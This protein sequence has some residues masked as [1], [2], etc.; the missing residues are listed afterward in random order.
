MSG[1]ADHL[2]QSTWFA[3]AAWLLAVLVRKDS[4]RIRYWIWLCAS[5]KFLV[6]FALLAWAGNHIVLE[7]EARS[8]VLPIVQQVA[9]PFAGPAISI[10]D[11]DSAMSRL[12][13]VIW[14]LGSGMLLVRW[15]VEWSRSRLLLRGADP[16]DIEAAVSVRC[17]DVVGAPAVVGILNPVIVLPR[18]LPDALTPA[19][20]NTVIAHETCHVRRRDNLMGLMHAIVQMI[21]WFHPLVWWVG[22]KLVQEREQACDES[23]VQGGGDSR[24]Y[25][26]TLVRV[27][28]HSLESRHMHAASV[29]GGDLSARVR[30]ILSYGS[31]LRV[32]VIRRGLV[33]TALL[34]CTALPVA[35]GMTVV[36][37]A[38][39]RIAADTLSMTVSRADAPAFVVMHD[40]YVYA[41]NISVRELISQ[42]YAVD[43]SRV[44][45]DGRSLDHPRYDIELR[46]PRDRRHDQ[47]QLVA[48]LLRRQFN[49]EL[50]VL[51]RAQPTG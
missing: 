9:A 41:R 10:G 16:C 48:D 27:C 46:G 36:T 18:Y 23:V 6:P 51:P 43:A 13:I 2:W 49:L 14:L 19:Q 33:A 44:T 39:L 34:V 25:A 3:L 20:M 32:C 42:V 4:A 21:F 1:I 22:T 24:T 26:E 28:R 37:A 12:A 47:Q 15:I 31:A 30:A 40:D 11:A 17:S 7:L 5:L 29:A 38:D 35:A 45:S 8:S 50:I